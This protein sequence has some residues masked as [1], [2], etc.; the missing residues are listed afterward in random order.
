MLMKVKSGVSSGRMPNDYIN[1][2]EG[3]L[4]TKNSKFS[5]RKKLRIV[6][7]NIYIYVY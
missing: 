1:I 2:R 3:N 7:L 5:Q 6:R 4:V